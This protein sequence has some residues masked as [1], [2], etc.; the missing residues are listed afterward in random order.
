[1][2][3]VIGETHS[4]L[5][6]T[7]PIL[8]ILAQCSQVDNVKEGKPD[9]LEKA[10]VALSEQH[11]KQTKRKCNPCQNRELNNQTWTSVVTGSW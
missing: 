3:T 10:L 8:D 2:I 6:L 1:M 11:R 5:L 4:L 7:T 9:N